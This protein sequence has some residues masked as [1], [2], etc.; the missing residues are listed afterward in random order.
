MWTT[1]RRS[2]LHNDLSGWQGGA[3]PHML[4]IHGVGMNANYWTNLIPQLQN[5]FSL[6]VIDLPGHGMSP[7]FNQDSLELADYTDAVARFIDQCA[8]PTTVVGHSM[9]AMIAIDLA[10]RF[11]EH[12]VAIAA[13]N[14]IHQRSDSAKA[15]VKARAEH[16]A[17][18]ADTDSTDSA[19]TLRRWFGDK[20]N[21]DYQQASDAC[22]KWLMAANPEG[23]RQAYRA[24]AFHDGPDD[25][26]LKAIGCPALFI[27][28]EDE[29]NST[30]AMSNA[31]ATLTK[32]GESVVVG[33]ARHMMSMTHGTEVINE[34]MTFA[35][36]HKLIV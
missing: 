32:H 19:D 33:G 15:A 36:T 25:A 1:L 3:G 23:Y 31:M 4:L 10:A 16:L 13:M 7:A 11:P 26:A 6:T 35:R 12:I 2:K 21:G 8:I 29:P 24:F 30:P 9:G 22:A 18:S 5:H 28:G 34:L 27:T 14:A 17:N 20:S